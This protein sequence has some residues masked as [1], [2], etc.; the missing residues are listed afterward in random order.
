MTDIWVPLLALHRETPA[1]YDEVRAYIEACRDRAYMY[2]DRRTKADGRLFV[3]ST[4]R[5]LQRSDRW[6]AAADQ[7]ATR[8]ELSA[9][10]WRVWLLDMCWPTRP[11]THPWLDNGTLHY[12]LTDD[13]K[14]ATRDVLRA[15]R[16]DRLV[17]AYADTAHGTVEDV[18][19]HIL[20]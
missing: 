16:D 9:D 11:S 8:L 4:I 2:S 15:F 6:Y 18:W 5:V 12:A 19:G 10:P 14:R 7:V 17:R 20:A 1:E 13:A 3:P